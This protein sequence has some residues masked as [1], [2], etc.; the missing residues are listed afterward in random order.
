MGMISEFFDTAHVRDDVAYWDALAERIADHAA[1]AS[2]ERAV[3]WLGRSRASWR[4]VVAG[5]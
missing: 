5:R 3:E 4:R 2:T 1:H